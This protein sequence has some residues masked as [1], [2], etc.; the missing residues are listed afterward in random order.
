MD[1]S[2]VQPV[3]KVC[4]MQGSKAVVVTISVLIIWDEIIDTSGVAQRGSGGMAV[5][6]GTN[7]GMARG[8]EK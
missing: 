8:A 1:V 6:D 7:I 3:V 2:V 5:T 4:V